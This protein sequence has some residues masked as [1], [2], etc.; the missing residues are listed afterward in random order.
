M[1]GIANLYFITKDVPFP[2]ISAADFRSQCLFV[3][4]EVWL[5]PCSV[6]EVHMQVH[7]FCASYFWLSHSTVLVIL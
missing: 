7:W 4:V 2:R 1:L 6:L 3:T 5:G